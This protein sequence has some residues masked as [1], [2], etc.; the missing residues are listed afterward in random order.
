ML[1]SLWASVVKG[2]VNS[3]SLSQCRSGKAGFIDI[4]WAL[5]TIFSAELVGGAHPT[6]PFPVRLS[7][8]GRE[9]PGPGPVHEVIKGP[10][11]KPAKQAHAERR[12]K[13]EGDVAGPF[14]DG[15]RHV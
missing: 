14:F 6:I 7:K 1:E 12:G 11:R 2:A 15:P 5:P 3:M 4:G 9:A 13:R 10:V 8:L